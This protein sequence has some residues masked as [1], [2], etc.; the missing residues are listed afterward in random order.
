VN[1]FTEYGSLEDPNSTLSKC[2]F[3]LV[4]HALTVFNKEQSEKKAE[5]KAS[6]LTDAEKLQ[7]EIKAFSDWRRAD[8]LDA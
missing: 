8:L 1:I 4:R 7:E 2:Q 5:L 6:S 3:L